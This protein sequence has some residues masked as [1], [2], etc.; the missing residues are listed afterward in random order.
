MWRFSS[1]NRRI[2]ELHPDYLNARIESCEDE[3]VSRLSTKGNT[4]S[5]VSSLVHSTTKITVREGIHCQ[6]TLHYRTK[7]YPFMRLHDCSK[8]NKFVVDTGTKQHFE[9]AALIANSLKRHNRT[10]TRAS[11]MTE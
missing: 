9:S 8:H 6:S 1:F 5:S 11:Y 3:G 2:N 10:P 4:P 7:Q